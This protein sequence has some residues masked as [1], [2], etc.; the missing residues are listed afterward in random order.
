MLYDDL[1]PFVALHPLSVYHWNKT[2]IC[3]GGHCIVIVSYYE[4]ANNFNNS[5][6]LCK[7]SFGSDWGD[8]G[9]FKIGFNECFIE[10]SGQSVV[11]VNQS[12]YAKIVP[13]LI[14]SLNTACSYGF[15]K[16]EWAQ[17]L[18]SVTVNSGTTLTI[19]SNAT[20]AFAN[21]A[22]LT[23]NGTLNADGNAS[24]QITFDRSA[25]TGTWG[26]IQFNS[27]SSGSLSY[28]NIKNAT[29]GVNCNGYLPSI[30]YCTISNNSTGINVVLNGTSQNHIA[31]NTIQNNTS[32]GISTAYSSFVCDHNTINNNGTYGIFCNN[33]MNSPGLSPVLYNNKITNHTI[34]LWCYISS[35]YL[36]V[37]DVVNHQ[38]NPNNKGYNVITQNGTGIRTAYGTVFL[39]QSTPG[40]L[41]GGYNSIFS[42]TNYAIWAYNDVTV[43]AQYNWWNGTPNIYQSSPNTVN[44]L[45][46]LTSNPNPLINNA[47][48]GTPIAVNSN[49]LL[50]TSSPGSSID[51]TTLNQ[52][53][54][55]PT[56]D[57]LASQALQSEF[58]GQTY[59]A[60]S[61]YQQ[62][63]MNERNTPLGRYALRKVN[64]CCWESNKKAVFDNYIKT[65]VRPQ[66]SKNDELSALL[67]E[68]ENQT[69]FENKN[70]DGIIRNLRG[71]LKDYKNIEPIYKQAL[72]NLGSLYLNTLNDKSKA[73]QYFSQLEAEFPEDMLV[74]SAHYQLG[75]DA[76][77]SINPKLSE[78]NNKEKNAIDTTQAQIPQGEKSLTSYPN[79]FNPSTVISY[80][81]SG[82]GT[83]YNVSLKVYDMLGR[84][85]AVLVEG[86][87]DAGYYKATFDASRLASGI[88][89]A[90]L[91]AT[92]QD[93]NKP[94][95]KTMK[96]LLTK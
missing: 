86:M 66:I 23:V 13:N 45:Y 49:L 53:S 62:I 81:L 47:P 39:G 16:S 43:W 14:S 64:E 30:T 90:R 34:G 63:F 91:V 89:F 80:Q 42:N 36:A 67:M 52:V 9:Y 10:C 87:K 58:Q 84:E 93:G 40:G 17:V 25:S 71:M 55:D 96:M 3:H 48:D 95:T 78:N 15:V 68:F 88:Y 54:E 92:P 44:W 51:D 20:L 19:P 35:P 38:G 8:G 28:C 94:F 85:V 60:I 22:S 6:W 77:L 50:K 11:T 75:K 32:C 72:Y 5:Y 65:S 12:C 69:L 2:P 74:L 70:F 1:G 41:Y 18:N 4:D 33:T 46:P 61:K 59:E 37:V 31:Y 29:I 82:E 7:N 73:T 57:D 27:G 56:N 21:G 79:P 76:G 83:R 26:T 24:Q